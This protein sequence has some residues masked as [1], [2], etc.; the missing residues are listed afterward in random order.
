MC[1]RLLISAL[2]AQAL[3]YLA[4]E[5]TVSDLDIQP[6]NG[7]AARQ[8]ETVNPFSPLLAIVAEALD[9]VHPRGQARD[10]HLHRGIERQAFIAACVRV[11]L[12]T[13][14]PFLRHRRFQSD[15]Q[16]EHQGDPDN[17]QSP[18]LPA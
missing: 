13:P 11:K 4:F 16:Q 3:L 17:E 8:R 14:L 6:V 9:H 10:F 15:Q 18:V 2:R 1:A 7:G 12:Q 5:D